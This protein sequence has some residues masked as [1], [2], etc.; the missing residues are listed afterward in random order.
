[1]WRGAAWACIVIGWGM[2]D[3]DRGGFDPPLPIRELDTPAQEKGPF[4]SADGLR[5]YFHRQAGRVDSDAA[6]STIWCA[7]RESLDAPF[8]EPVVVLVNGGDPTLTPDELTIVFVRR[9]DGP[10]G[11]NLDLFTATRTSRDSA[12]AA[13]NPI[14]D[15]NT[16]SN[17]V[18][19]KL[20]RDGV[21]LYFASDRPGGRGGYDIWLSDRKTDGSGFGSP[22]NLDE[23]NG[24][25][26]EANPEV[27]SD[28]LSIYFASDRAGGLGHCDLYV[29]TRASRFDR[30]GTPRNL[31]GLNSP[32][33]DKAPTL[34]ADGR[35]LVFRS[36]RAGGAGLSDL[37]VTR[38]TNEAATPAKR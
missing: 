12:F 7:S 20:T 4:L 24:P 28:G 15:L 5:L 25:S 31:E 29:A 37:Y 19:P 6:E 18:G 30:F 2:L 36:S 13:A 32:M 27:T 35:V 38:R 22:R 33:P 14:V 10:A 9:A 1:M 34:S 21:A 3:G 16:P 26:E 17:E 8:R 23:L 11:A